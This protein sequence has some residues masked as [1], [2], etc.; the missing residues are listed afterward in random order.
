MQVY[1]NYQYHDQRLMPIT[2]KVKVF[3]EETK[4]D[5]VKDVPFTLKEVLS[6]LV[7]MTTKS[8][9]NNPKMAYSIGI[10]I[11]T[12]KDDYL[13]LSREETNYL[14]DLVAQKLQMNTQQG[15][16]TVDREPIIIAQSQLV[17]DGENPWDKIK[18]T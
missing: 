11:E 5:E 6:D 13:E 17:L 2:K 15:P 1:I 10:K 18:S 9:D 14:S 8:S 12:C 7:F 16:I 4:V 3:N